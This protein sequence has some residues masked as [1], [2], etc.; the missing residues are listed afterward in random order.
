MVVAITLSAGGRTVY[1][2]PATVDQAQCA[3]GVGAFERD[4]DGGR[5]LGAADLAA[6]DAEVLDRPPVPHALG[7]QGEAVID[8]ANEIHGLADGTDR[9]GVGHGVVLSALV[10]FESSGPMPSESALVGGASTRV[11]CADASLAT[12]SSNPSSARSHI[13]SR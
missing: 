8:A 13:R 6:A 2:L 11:L 10:G 1:L 9:I 5:H 4:L 3:R 12:K 7:E